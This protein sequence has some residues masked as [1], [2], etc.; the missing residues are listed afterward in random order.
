MNPI[1]EVENLTAKYGETT[2]LKDVNVQIFPNQI[3]V[4]LGKSGCGKTTLLKN[5]I[6]L[7]QPHSGRIKIFDQDVTFMEEKEFNQ[8]LR[9]IGV[10]FQNGALLNSLTVGEN[11]SIPIEQH[12]K[13]HPS[14]IHRVVRGKLGLVELEHAIGMY[15]SELSGGMKK[16]AA[17]ARSIAMDPQ[18]LFGDEPSAG[19]DPITAS[20]LDRLL[21]KLRDHLDMT[22]V[23]VS[24]ELASIQRI[25][26]R[27]IFMDDG[28]I[29]FQGKLEDAKKE[30]NPAMQKF[31]NP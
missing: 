18:I 31:F 8:I 27:I 17:L 20:A 16:R 15:P 7:Y 4:I 22:M 5:I 13:L 14:L 6:R 3:T 2:V 12:T 1:I 21:F 25:A 30:E 23:I 9:K 26:E 29:L 10:L 11:V 24:H 19:L 28:K